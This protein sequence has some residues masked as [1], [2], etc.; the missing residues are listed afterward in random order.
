MKAFISTILVTHALRTSAF[1]AL[2]LGLVAMAPASAQD[3]TYVKNLAPDSLSV[4]PADFSAA[5]NSLA[6]HAASRAPLN[7][8]GDGNTSSFL[9]C[10]AANSPGLNGAFYRT[11]LAITT[12]WLSSSMKVNIFGISNNT[13]PLGNPSAIHGGS[14][15]L[16]GVL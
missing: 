5:V 6:P 12:R 16:Q 13:A 11:E 2:F 10:S 7:L 14:F 3:L 15:T 9:V 8:T 4:S 1:T